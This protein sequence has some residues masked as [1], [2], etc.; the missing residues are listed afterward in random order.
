MSLAFGISAARIAAT[1]A[2]REHDQ[3]VT[4]EHACQTCPRLGAW[5]GGPTGIFGDNPALSLA[6]RNTPTSFPQEFI[7]DVISPG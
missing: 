2:G 3:G 7:N 1:D 5:V 6:R 4:G